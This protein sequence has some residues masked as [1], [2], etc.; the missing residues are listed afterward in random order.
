MTGPR[1]LARLVRVDQDVVSVTL[2]WDHDGF[3]VE[4]EHGVLQV[5]HPSALTLRVEGGI[6]YCVHRGRQT[7][8]S[9]VD[10]SEGREEGGGSRDGR[11][12]APMHGKLIALTVH[13]G[14]R[15]TKGQR[16]AVIEAMKMEHA[17]LAPY[18]GLVDSV[19]AELGQQIGEGALLLVI[20]AEEA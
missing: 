10:P 18:D 9:L 11:M 1:R 7:L 19:H 5:A 6:A 4:D 20:A 14:E 13:Q 12:R 15:V 17:L 3:H 8:V 2:V 16:V